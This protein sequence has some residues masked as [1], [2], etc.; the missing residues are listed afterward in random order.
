M[1]TCIIKVSNIH[2]DCYTYKKCLCTV[3]IN[4]RT[5]L[6]T[7]SCAHWQPASS[8][9]VTYLY[10]Q[11]P[12]SLNQYL[13]DYQREGIQFLY[14]HYVRK[15]GAILGDDMGLGKTVQ[16]GHINISAPYNFVLPICPSVESS[17]HEGQ[18]VL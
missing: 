10:S 8:N 17:N 13:R 3:K 15:R 6:C 18:C 4:S 9:S 2:R 16:V 11:I 7:F 12:A 5:V 1:F 14:S